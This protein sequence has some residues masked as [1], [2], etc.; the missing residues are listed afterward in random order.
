L[1]PTTTK[2]EVARVVRTFLK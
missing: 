1:E 2:K